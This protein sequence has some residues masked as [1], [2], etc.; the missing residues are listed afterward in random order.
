[1]RGEALE[2]KKGLVVE[3][4]ERGIERRPLT[5]E[6]INAELPLP[7]WGGGGGGGGVSSWSAKGTSSETQEGERQRE[8][9]LFSKPLVKTEVMTEPDEDVKNSD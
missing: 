5:A 2:R 6:G 8:L 4:G 7:C 9:P 1:M 3:W